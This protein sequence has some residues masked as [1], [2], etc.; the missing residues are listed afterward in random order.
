MLFQESEWL[1]NLNASP[2]HLLGAQLLFLH[3]MR[4]G[5]PSSKHQIDQ[6]HCQGFIFGNQV[7]LEVA[8]KWTSVPGRDFHSFHRENIPYDWKS[9]RNGTHSV[10][11]SLTHHKRYEISSFPQEVASSSSKN[12]LSCEDNEKNP[13]FTSG[14][15][16]VEIES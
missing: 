13:H 10:M 7:V 8:C 9:R 12:K 3:R 5:N 2:T 6:Y 4:K 16:K 14:K 11:W 15:L 1:T